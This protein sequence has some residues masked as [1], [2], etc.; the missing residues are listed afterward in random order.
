[1]NGL[2]QI[3]PDSMAV[4][5]LGLLGLLI[6]LI[7]SVIA[8]AGRE[9][10]TKEGLGLAL[11]IFLLLLGILEGPGLVKARFTKP[12]VEETVAATQ[13]E[14]PVEP[15]EPA[16]AETVA[17]APALEPAPAVEEQPR[18][19]APKPVPVPAPA[20]T[21]AAKPRVV[22]QEQ[23]KPAPVAVQPLPKPV[24]QP[25]PKPVETPPPPRTAPGGGYRMTIGPSSAGTGMIDIQIRGPI[26]ETS[27]SMASSAHLM[28]VLD[29]KHTLIIP[30]TR[31][32]EQKKENE[33]GEQV[34]STVTYFW[35]NIH[36]AFDNVPPGPHAVMIDVSL[37][38]PTTHKS[39][40]IGAGNL[41]NDYNAMVQVSEGSAVPMVFASKNWMTQELERIK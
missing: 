29:S 10:K 3:S 6:A 27:K 15:V 40:M 37:A 26:L 30:P 33:F 11:I 7:L 17:E 8:A 12:P 31:Y 32:K 13:P 24:V 38:S 4:G 39:K 34:L 2:L 25:A 19:V 9:D 18:P 16:P 22:I 35:E 28:I 21:P 41:E 1:M 23:P 14:A 20:P 5:Y 36:A